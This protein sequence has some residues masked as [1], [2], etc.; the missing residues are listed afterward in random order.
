MSMPEPKV[1]APHQVG[2]LRRPELDR[3]GKYI[4]ELPDGSLIAHYSPQAPTLMVT[5]TV[6]RQ[7]SR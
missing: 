1:C 3:K 2:W 6:T 4:W 7:I 5:R